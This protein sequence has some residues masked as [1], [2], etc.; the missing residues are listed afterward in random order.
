MSGKPRQLI[1]GIPRF[2]LELA[3]KYYK[4]NLMTRISFYFL[5]QFCGKAFKLR[6]DLKRHTL[7]HTGALRVKYTYFTYLFL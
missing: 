5:I 4:I 7:I 3:L 1:C 2:E 6:N